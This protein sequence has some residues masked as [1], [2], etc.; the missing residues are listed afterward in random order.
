MWRGELESQLKGG[1]LKE[2]RKVEKDWKQN[3]QAAAMFELKC[4][5]AGDPFSVPSKT[6]GWRVGLGAKGRQKGELE[7]WG[8]TLSNRQATA[9]NLL[10]WCE[11]ALAILAGSSSSSGRGPV[12]E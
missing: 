4:E 7:D 9:V 5:H 10:S 8:R 11:Y 6:A 12:R 3:L 2:Q 1:Q